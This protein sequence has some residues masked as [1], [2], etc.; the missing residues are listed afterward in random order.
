MQFELLEV[1][2]D[3]FFLLKFSADCL[4]ISFRLFRYL[5]A[6]FRRVALKVKLLSLSEFFR[7]EDL[8]AERSVIVLAIL[9]CSPLIWCVHMPTFQSSF[10]FW[11][12]VHIAGAT[13]F[14]CFSSS[15]ADFSSSSTMIG[16]IRFASLFWCSCCRD[17]S[18]ACSR[19]SAFIWK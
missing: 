6:E 16:A 17:I 11:I 9:W 10:L 8:D 15:R 19:Y 12:C 3:Q 18:I 7:A 14:A 13:K 5:L 1:N 4:K 2:E